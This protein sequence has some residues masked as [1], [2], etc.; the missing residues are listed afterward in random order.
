MSGTYELDGTRGDNAERAASAATRNLPPGQ[1]DRA[2]QNLLN[3][4][5]APSTI[6]L[7]RQGRTVT[8]SSS[9]G[10]RT[11]FD[12][13]GQ[14]RHEPWLDGRTTVTHAEFIG[15]RL[16]VSTSGGNRNAD[17][18][19]TFE[20][21]NNGDGLLVTRRFDSDD[22][23]QP[24][25][26]RSYYR[27]VNVQPRWD[28]Y[29]PQP[30]YGQAPGYTRRSGP[31]PFTVPEGTRFSAVL[32]TSL[33]TRTSRSG[34]RFSMTVEGPGEYR[35]A[36]IEGVVYRVTQGRNADMLVD[37]DTIRLRNGETAE[38]DGV[39]NTVRTPGGVTLRVSFFFAAMMPL[40]VA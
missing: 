37:F 17:F 19:V 28:V 22:L 36:Q 9:N 10:P 4:L 30:G 35:G 8:I 34:E 13:D 7:D 6:A 24:V 16:S 25:T 26:A 1:R 29:A 38:F 32:D 18:L 14:Q 3:R 27:R 11:S 15:D 23:R 33:S 40:S 5:Q 12:A 31:R 20:P 21:L 39:L 2:Y